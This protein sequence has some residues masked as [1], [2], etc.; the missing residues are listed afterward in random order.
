MPEVWTPPKV[1]LGDNLS[2][3]DLNLSLY[4]A[5]MLALYLTTHES[6]TIDNYVLP[7]LR[8]ERPTDT[9]KKG[10]DDEDDNG[11]ED[12]GRPEISDEDAAEAIKG[13]TKA[14]KRRG[15]F[16]GL[17]MELLASSILQHMDRCR[18]VVAW[19]KTH[20]GRP[21]S[22]APGETSGV[23]AVFPRT[24][25][26]REFR[27]LAEVSA[28]RR[29][30]DIYY[31]IQL[32]E[33]LDHGTKEAEKYPGLLVYALVINGAKIGEDRS[34]YG[35]YHSFLAENDVDL[36]GNVR[37]VPINVDD[38]AVAMGQL[39]L[40]LGPDSLYYSSDILMQTLEAV[41]QA[42][43]PATLPDEIKEGWMSALLLNS[44]KEGVAKAQQDLVLGKGPEL[45]F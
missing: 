2:W 5:C 1:L 41:Y 17:A 23:T 43:R 35:Q 24:E 3:W 34:Y 36:A 45:P 18:Q 10:K 16:K 39:F 33:A 4:E 25:S 21:S 28:K 22:V 42:V 14:A 31:A 15:A 32:D 26:C 40:D 44:V 12:D 11:G 19:A 30:T 38:F 29:M 7:Y 6:T 27:I 37:I 13:P 20:N 8:I 9:K